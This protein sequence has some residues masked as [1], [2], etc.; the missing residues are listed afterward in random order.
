MS[1]RGKSATPGRRRSYSRLGKEV[2]PVDLDALLLPKAAKARFD[3]SKVLAALIFL[4]SVALLYQFY[5]SP[6]FRV[7]QV[8]VRGTRLLARTKVEAA[9]DVRGQSLFTI[10]TAE[11]IDRLQTQFGNLAHISASCHLPNRVVISVREKHA[12]LAWY[13]GERYWWVDKEGNI[14]GNDEESGGSAANP[15]EL[16]IVVIRDVA[17]IAPQPQSFVVGVPWELALEMKAALPAIQEF[18]YTR[19][20]GL[21]LYV[22]EER[23]PVYLGHEGDAATK[24]A[25][26][27]ALVA[28]LSQERIPAKYLD[29]RDETAPTFE[30]RDGGKDRTW[31]GQ[32][33]A[34]I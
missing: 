13:S 9:A 4:G 24:V 17:S 29:L 5:A 2:S 25:V 14:L 3:W 18:D 10:C 1:K 21:I 31:S 26:M 34:L 27:Q 6:R 22:T 30:R 11:L 8:I 12:V 16:G 33:L 7:H 15:S 23:W 19:E 32:S 28:R 20:H